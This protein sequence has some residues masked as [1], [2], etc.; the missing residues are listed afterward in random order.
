M[1]KY[2]IAILL[3]FLVS[4]AISQQ[5]LPSIQSFHLE[6]DGFTVATH[7]GEFIS[8][9]PFPSE[10]N[11]YDGTATVKLSSSLNAKIGSVNEDTITFLNVEE[12]IGDYT[13]KRTTEIKL[14]VDTVNSL[15]TSLS[16][17]YNEDVKHTLYQ[18][19]TNSEMKGVSLKNIPYIQIGDT[20]F[21]SLDSSMLSNSVTKV[22]YGR[23]SSSRFSYSSTTGSYSGLQG[24]AY[25]KGYFVKLKTH[26][27]L[28]TP[29]SYALTLNPDMINRRYSADSVAFYYRNDSPDSVIIQNIKFID[30]YSEYLTITYGDNSALSSRKTIL[31]FEKNH[32]FLLNI[33]SNE[34]PH[35]SARSI[36]F[37]VTKL[38]NGQ[39][40]L[41][42]FGLGVLFKNFDYQSNIQ[43]GEP[44]PYNVLYFDCNVGDTVDKDV[45]IYY[46]N[47]IYGLN[48]Q[49][50]PDTTSYSLTGIDHQNQSKTLNFRFVPPASGSY[51]YRYSFQ[52]LVKDFRG[53]VNTFD[54]PQPIVLVAYVQPLESVKVESGIHEFQVFPNPASTKINV[55]FPNHIQHNVDVSL[56]NVFGNRVL[57]QELSYSPGSSVI[58]LPIHILPGN[59]TVVLRDNSSVYT[60][61]VVVL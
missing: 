40:L 37:V 20:L 18:Y 39:Q 57:H 38:I 34:G 29:K 46:T 54:Y 55:V 22:S 7:T 2:P 35:F 51:E 44:L 25:L 50:I 19:I 56:L 61:K 33:R 28:V 10:E 27:S 36:T 23:G 3:S 6:G 30:D 5:I 26:S 47:Q 59:Y 32:K 45:Q 41:D 58:E 24:N 21:F 43:V 31:P 49:S 15:I 13:V 17:S 11:D 14:L 42:T 60:Y 12:T 52:Y 9:V 4:T 48:F 53:T 16:Y 8:H 1:V